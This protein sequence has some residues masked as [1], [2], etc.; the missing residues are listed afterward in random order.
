MWSGEEG[1]K[2]TKGMLPGRQSLGPLALILVTSVLVLFMWR[3]QADLDGSMLALFNDVKAHGLGGSLGLAWTAIRPTALTW[4]VLGTFAAF[5]LFCQ[6]CLP[7]ELYSGP[8]T[9]KGNTPRYC[10]NGFKAF[11]ANLV[12]Y[13]GAVH[14]GLFEGGILADE[15]GRMFCAL[16]GVALVFC[17]FLTVKGLNFPSSSDSGSNGSWIMD[18]YWG[19][20]LYPRILGWDVKLFTNS[21]FGLM[22]WVLLPISFCY[23]S[24]ELD[25]GVLSLPLAVNV[26]LQLVYLSKFYWWE[27]GYMRSIDI[28]QDRAGYY[29]C[30]G[31]L[32]WVPSFYTSH[33]QF[34]FFHRAAIVANPMWSA[35]LALTFAVLG[36]V[37][38]FINYDADN[39]VRVRGRRGG[40]GWCG[41]ERD[42]G[43]TTCT[44]TRT[45][46]TH[47]QHI[48]HDCILSTP[49]RSVFRS[50]NGNCNVFGAPATMVR[51]TY[52]AADGKERKSILL[53]SGY[54]SV[55]RHF[56]YIPELTATFFWS[57]PALFTHA[58][59]FA[60]LAFLVVLLFD[61]AFR[62]DARCKDKYGKYWD[63]YRSIVPYKVIPGII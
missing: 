3:M 26:F 40:A 38:I 23:K 62:D 39:Q 63:Q 5:Q 59:P 36:W 57:A 8:V 48:M 44:Q 55:S 45:T 41:M 25:G 29:I 50:T 22:M 28:M 27:S 1:A 18:F 13:Y 34:I 54:W 61:R 15:A 33:T 6:R 12:C 32:V 43:T 4:K 14:Y 53:T 2:S 42:G 7:G 20:E 60:Y 11:L 19:T 51:A 49:Q 52:M 24:M 31:C 46:D 17:V 47:I 10:D 37:S 56:H 35:S 58:W 21:R 9:P 16:N 30:W